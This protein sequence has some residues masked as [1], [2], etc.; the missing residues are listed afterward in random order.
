MLTITAAQMATLGRHRELDFR[1]RAVTYLSDS[2]PALAA[3]VGER[4]SEFLDA[5]KALADQ[6]GLRSELAVMT[7]CELVAVHGNRF[8][9]DNAWASYLLLRCEAEPVVRVERLRKYLPRPDRLQPE[10]SDA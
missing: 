1:R 8:H 7:V 5:A 9:H 10:L 6:G 3:M 2:Y 4:W